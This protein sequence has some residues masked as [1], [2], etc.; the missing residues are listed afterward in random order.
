[1]RLLQKQ[2]FQAFWIGGIVRN[3]L[4]KKESDNVDIA[5]DALPEEIEKVLNNAELKSK[6]VGKQFGSILAIVDGFKIEITTF[7]AEGRY[8][9]KRHPDQVEFIKDYLDDAKRRDFTIN[10]IYFDPV[11]KMLYDPANGIKDLRL[12]L[13]RFVGDPKK[14]IDEDALRMLRGVRLATQLGFKLE[15]NSFAAIKT[16][17]KYIQGISG[18]RVKAELD[19]ILLSESRIDGLKLMDEIGLLRFIIPQVE[20]LKTFSHTSI[21]YHLEGNMFNHTLLAVGKV[22]ENDLDLIYAVL[23]HDIGKPQSQHRVE[24]KNGWVSSTKGHPLVSA[25][26]FNE[27]ARRLKFSRLSQKLI[28]WLILNHEVQPFKQ[29]DQERQVIFALDP[30]FDLLLK[31]WQADYEGNIRDD[32][33]GQYAKVVKDAYDLGIG[34][35]KKIKKWKPLI[36]KLARGGLIMKYGKLKPGI[37][38]GRGIENV[39]AQIVLGKIKNEEDLKKYLNP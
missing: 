7:R 6:P 37:E 20:A 36:G 4:F 33:D 8:S 39:K 16:R 19:K 5:T 12:K 35:A 22:K 14:R 29:L 28:E 27:F 21:H 32:E 11:K 38:V 17:S 1:M 24:K 23:F 9:D 3:I 18:E 34:L 26:I 31:V 10:A 30:R 25:K 15:K 13:L 2:G